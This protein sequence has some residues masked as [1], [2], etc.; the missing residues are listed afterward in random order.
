MILFPLL[1]SL[2]VSVASLIMGYGT[3]SHAEGLSE[4]TRW[5]LP[6]GALWVFAQ[7]KRWR[8]FAP[9]GLFAALVAAAYGLWLDLPSGWM[10]AG[11]LGALFAWDLSDFERRLQ[12][13][14][15]EDA[16]SLLQR[17]LVRL[18]M[19]AAAGLAYS[20]LGMLYWWK[21]SLEWVGYAA[22]LSALGLALLVGRLRRSRP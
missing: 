9:I 16:P 6:F 4:W 12:A 11:A 18:G 19:L 5:M 14:G 21:F 1:V 3:A 20:L 13:S 2:L 17:H 10:L 7:F 22:L 15:P 8:W